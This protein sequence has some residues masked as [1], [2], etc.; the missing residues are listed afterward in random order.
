MANK[1]TGFSNNLNESRITLTN[2]VSIRA[3]VEDDRQPV[4]L[5]EQAIEAV[6]TSEA[7]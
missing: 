1:R 6:K 3:T 7:T 2:T 5:S 4:M